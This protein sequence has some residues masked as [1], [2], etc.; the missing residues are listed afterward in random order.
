MEDVNFFGHFGP[1]NVVFSCDE[2]INI[3]M[4]QGL[5]DTKEEEEHEKIKVFCN[6]TGLNVS[7]IEE[8]DAD[9]SFYCRVGDLLS[10]R[11]EGGDKHWNLHQVTCPKIGKVQKCLAPEEEEDS[12]LTLILETSSSSLILRPPLKIKNESAQPLELGVASVSFTDEFPSRSTTP[13]SENSRYGALR[14]LKSRSY[15]QKIIWNYHLS[16]NEG[17]FLRIN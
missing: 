14:R 12:V 11:L 16:P 2:F 9:G 8:I 15:Q 5:L 4:P 10:F 13:D 1:Q 3:N 6:L 7:R 17:V